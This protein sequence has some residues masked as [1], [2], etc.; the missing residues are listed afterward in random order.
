MKNKNIFPK[1]SRQNRRAK[2]QSIPEGRY[3]YTTRGEWLT[4]AINGVEK[5]YIEIVYCKFMTFSKYGRKC[6]AIG[7]K[8]GEKSYQSSFNL[9]WDGCKECNFKIE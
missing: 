6:T 1:R 8:C 3:C 7:L 4:K 2:I 5:A 9:L